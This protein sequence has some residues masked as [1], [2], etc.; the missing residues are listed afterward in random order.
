[1]HMNA[2]ASVCDCPGLLQFADNFLNRDN[3]LILTDGTDHL[4]LIF[5]TGRNLTVARLTM[6]VD[7]GVTH[8]LPLTVLTVQ[9]GVGI[10]VSSKVTGGCSKV[11]SSHFGGFFAGNAGHFNLNAE[12]LVF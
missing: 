8:K 4:C 12:A 10:I 9:C 3:I 2:A 6:R 11:F 5:D 1:M 7:T